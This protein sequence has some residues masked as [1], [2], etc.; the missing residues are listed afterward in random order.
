MKRF[1]TSWPVDQQAK[2]QLNNN[3]DYSKRK[4]SLKEKRDL[5]SNASVVPDESK[6]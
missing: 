4:V 1:S 3:H 6:G 2:I 5:A